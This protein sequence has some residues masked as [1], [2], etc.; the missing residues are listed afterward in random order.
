MSKLQHGGKTT[1]KALKWPSS[2][3]PHGPSLENI[4]SFLA[5]LTVDSYP[6]FASVSDQA[7]ILWARSTE[8]KAGQIEWFG[9]IR[10]GSQS[11]DS[12]QA[13][14]WLWPSAN[15]TTL[16][17]KK[18]VS[19]HSQDLSYNLNAFKFYW[20]TWE[21]DGI[22]SKEG[23]TQMRACGGLPFRF[24]AHSPLRRDLHVPIKHSNV[25]LVLMH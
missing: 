11:W 13:S 14:R 18:C 22:L 21:R 12:S 19:A 2:P 10:A 17:P 16:S 23:S 7:K 25:S 5:G 20:P 8:A 1:P 3:P 15:S 4:L 6:G 24:P 9:Q